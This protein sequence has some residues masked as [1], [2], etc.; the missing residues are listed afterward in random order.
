[1][2][3]AKWVDWEPQDGDERPNNYR[4][5]P[6]DTLN[7]SLWVVGIGWGVPVDADHIAAF[8]YQVLKV[9]E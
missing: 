6:R 1:M 3:D 5:Q 8:R 9:G 4:Y 7:P 2:S